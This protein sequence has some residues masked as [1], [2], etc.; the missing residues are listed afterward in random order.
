MRVFVGKKKPQGRKQSSRRNYHDRDHKIAWLEKEMDSCGVLWP[1]VLSRCLCDNVEMWRV[2]CENA[3][4]YIISLLWIF[5]KRFI[6]QPI[7][8]KHI[9]ALR[10]YFYKKYVYDL[11]LFVLTYLFRFNSYIKEYLF[12]KKNHQI[13]Q[14]I[15]KSSSSNP[16]HFTHSV[17]LVALRGHR[18]HKSDT[19]FE[20]SGARE[21][22]D[23]GLRELFVSR[24]CCCRST[25]IYQP[26][27]CQNN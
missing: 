25:R 11:N 6:L 23:A 4:Q 20:N 21:R 2:M 3:L 26:V 9:Y 15:E 7:A 12:D 1:F 24:V 14:N 18:D 17:F 27:V 8:C 22:P 5:S 10:N 16:I 13:I 19:R